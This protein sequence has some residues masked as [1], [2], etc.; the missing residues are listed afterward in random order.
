MNVIYPIMLTILAL[1]VLTG[2][3]VLLAWKK[4][5]EQPSA[6][7]D[8]RTFFILGICCFPLGIVIISAE[9]PFGYV[10]LAWGLV[11]LAVGLYLR[12]RS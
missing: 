2:I 1:A 7:P 3:I 6:E 5:K 9:I 4:R 11:Y 10:V 8:Y 12:W